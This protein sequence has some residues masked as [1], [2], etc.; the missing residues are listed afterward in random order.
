MSHT[1]HSIIMRNLGIS[2]S[3]LPHRFRTNGNSHNISN[4]SSLLLN[5]NNSSSSHSNNILLLLSNML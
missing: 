1:L 2:L 3:M 5:G 4:F